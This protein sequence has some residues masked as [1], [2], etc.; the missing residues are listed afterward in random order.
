MHPRTW[1]ILALV[2]LTRTVGAWEIQSDPNHPGAFPTL[3]ACDLEYVFGWS[4][5]VESAKAKVQFRPGVEESRATVTGETIGATRLIWSMDARH[6]AIIDPKTL[7]GKWVEQFEQYRGRSIETGL[8]FSPSD[9]VLR[10]RRVNP[11]ARLTAR[12]KRFRVEDAFDVLGGMLFV[13]SQP[14]KP[15]DHLRILS[16]P[17]DSAYVVHLMVRD[18]ETILVHGKETRA[19]RMDLRLEKIR[20]EKNY[21]IGLEDY[22]KFRAGT[23]WFSDNELRLPVR[24]EVKVFVGSVTGELVRATFY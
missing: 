11:D 12:W 17:G 5:L 2:L 3:P 4:D 1:R 23:V 7:R 14:L 10:F 6:D 9:S 18:R 21:P 8:D 13:R 19:I 15:G 24:A 16:F 22:Q 20:F